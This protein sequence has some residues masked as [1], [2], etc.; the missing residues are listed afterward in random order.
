MPTRTTY[1]F[2]QVVDAHARAYGP[3][4]RMS[5]ERIGD[6]GMFS[7]PGKGALLAYTWERDI[8][9]IV[10]AMEMHVM[11]VPFAEVARR[12][13]SNWK[14]YNAWCVAAERGGQGGRPP[15]FLYFIGDANDEPVIGIPAAELA[16][17]WKEAIEG[18][19]PRFSMV[20]LTMRLAAMKKALE[21]SPPRA[22]GRP[23]KATRATAEPQRRIFA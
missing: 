4:A 23:R 18:R 1:V 8:R 14:D 20:N 12:F 13:K 15:V 22:R 7:K 17:Y 11:G 3:D 9:R 19:L 2:S 6:V 10:L 16:K 21:A 5:L